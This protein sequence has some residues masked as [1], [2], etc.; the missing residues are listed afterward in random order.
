MKSLENEIF[1][2]LSNNVIA[3]KGEVNQLLAV[4]E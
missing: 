2:G 3:I 1:F 4:I